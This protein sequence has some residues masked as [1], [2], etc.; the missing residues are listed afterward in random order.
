MVS[1]YF[2]SCVVLTHS[3]AGESDGLAVT[4]KGIRAQREI[5]ISSRMGRM[6]K[7]NQGDWNDIRKH[8]NI[9]F[10][11]LGYRLPTLQSSTAITQYHAYHQ[12]RHHAH[13][14]RI[15]HLSNH[16]SSQ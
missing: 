2:H 1:F 12:H 11:Y 15:H 6:S 16:R 13:R 5:Q 3:N 8:L 14:S 9:M 7:G 4:L 10:P